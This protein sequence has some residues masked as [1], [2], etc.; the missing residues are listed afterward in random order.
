[1]SLA[2]RYDRFLAFL[3][4]HERPL[5]TALFIT[6]FVTDLVTFGLLSLSKVTLLFA[7][8]LAIAIGATL[9][10]H[11]THGKQANAFV[12]SAAVLSPLAAQ[13]V[14]GSVLSGFLIFYTKS[15]VLAVSWPFLILLALVFFGNELFRNYRS[16]LIFQALLVYFSLYAL[17]LF[18]VP[19]WLGEIGTRT[20]L[21]STGLTV[22]AFA[23]YIAALAAL[24]HARLVE[25]LWGI[26]GSSLVLTVCIVGSHLGGLLPPIPL[27]LKD[28]GVYQSITKDSAGGYVL[29]GENSKPWYDPR[30]QEVRHRPG[31]PLYVYSAIFAPIEFS[32][33]VVHVWQRYDAETSRWKTEATVAFDVSGGREAGYRGYSLKSDPAPGKWRVLVQTLNGQTIGD[34][35]FNVSNSSL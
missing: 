17:L 15:A 32:A 9:I 22:I 11:A 19:L 24:R 1:M 14:F 30:P 3:M 33:S 23:L 2:H 28:A 25:A 6:G 29:Q 13:F 8:Y 35:R 21:L 26:L 16:H 27:A 31:T 20:F 34:L 7:V 18:V 12:R 10:A 5:A 4:R